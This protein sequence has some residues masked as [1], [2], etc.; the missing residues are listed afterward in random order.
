MLNHIAVSGHLPSWRIRI[1]GDMP[2]R[3]VVRLHCKP[4]CS[5][6]PCGGGVLRSSLVVCDG[7]K[8]AVAAGSHPPTLEYQQ[9][10][11]GDFDRCGGEAEQGTLPYR[12]PEQDRQ[13][14]EPDQRPAYDV[15]VGCQPGD[16]QVQCRQ[17]REV[18]EAVEDESW[19]G[20]QER[21]V[22]DGGDKREH[23]H[24]EPD[25]GVRGRACRGH[26]SAPSGSNASNGAEAAFSF[27]YTYMPSYPVR[28]SPKRRALPQKVGSA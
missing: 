26:A 12:H 2:T 20:K 9:D 3:T 15:S 28:S 10:D 22:N 23:H 17:Q 21:Q 6:K 25:R 11:Q 27:T 19:V 7:L 5:P 1:S 8:T 14:R 16:W 4:L 24:T 18:P 13:R